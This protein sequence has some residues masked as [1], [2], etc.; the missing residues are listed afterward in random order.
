MPTLEGFFQNMGRYFPLEVN[1]Q[2]GNGDPIMVKLYHV[3]LHEDYNPV[4]NSLHVGRFSYTIRAECQGKDIVFEAAPFLPSQVSILSQ[5]YLD[6]GEDDDDDPPAPL[7]LSL[8]DIHLQCH[9]KFKS[10]SHG[11]QR[12]RDSVQS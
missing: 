6:N 5:A 3:L 2:Q 4:F 7:S 8:L 10:Q 9:S 1:A 12:K 11:Q